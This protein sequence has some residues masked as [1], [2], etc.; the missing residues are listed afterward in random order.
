LTALKDARFHF[1]I[2]A[3]FIGFGIQLFSNRAAHLNAMTFKPQAEA[4]SACTARRS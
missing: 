3:A 4:L 2:V 1:P